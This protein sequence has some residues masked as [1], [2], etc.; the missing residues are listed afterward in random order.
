VASPTII[1]GR[2][3]DLHVP[4]DRVKRHRLL[5]FLTA[6]FAAKFVVLLQLY[7]HP[8]LQANAGL[9]TTVYTSLAAK[10]LA[11]NPS[12]APGLYFV[13]PLYIYFLAAILSVS[14]SLAFARLVQIALGTAAV[15]MMFV[16]AR[17]WF[18]E[19]AGWCAAVLAALTGLFTFH[20]VLILQAALD[21]FLT[22]AALTA[23]ALA[24]TA[25]RAQMWF[26]VSGIAFG[27]QT[28]NRPSVLIP[29]LVV[30]ALLSIARRWRP[31]IFMAAG[32]AIAL[33]P[34]VIRNGIVARD[35]SPASSHGGLN[36]YIGNNADANGT[37]HLVPG[38][39]PN[40][41]GQQEDARRVAEASVGRPLDDSEVAAYFYGLGWTWIR[42]HPKD[43][44]ALFARKL[45]YTFSSAYITLNYSYPFYAYDARTLL[46]LLFVGP[47][48]LIPVG[49]VGL[50]I[51]MPADRRF[52]Y[53]VWVSFVPVYAIAVATF[54]VTERYRLPMLVPLCMGSGVTVD[55]IFRLKAEA[56]KFK[57][58]KA[59]GTGFQPEIFALLAIIPLA[60]LVNWPVHL[61]DG[62]AEERTRMAEAMVAGDEYDDAEEWVQ[63]AERDH[64]SPGLLHFRVARA[65]IL[66]RQPQR[67]IDH[68][69][70]SIQ[71]DPNRPEVDYAYGQALVDAG[72]SAE[73]IPHLRN[74]MR[75][76]VRVDLAGYDLARALAATGNRAG[77]LQ[78]L[79]TV[80]PE[81]PK[82]AD[83]W[84]ALGQLA[85]QLESPSLAAAFFNQALAA[86]P[87]TAKPMADLGL[88]LAMMGRYPEAI[89]NFTHA[90]AL[91][92]AN[93]A[94]ELNLAVAYAETGR[95][96]EARAHAEAA[97]RLKPDYA[98]ARQFLAALPRGK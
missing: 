2:E 36:F 1:A 20:E 93:A 56:T 90:L 50:V 82:D 18:G 12:L 63:K 45:G 94:T 76:G 65:Y 39:T 62:R 86:A 69:K 30:L 52:E 67:A 23:L 97:L 15:W 7:D 43:A 95:I 59:N 55:A 87:Q 16:G 22:A 27:I 26:A 57:R 40:I 31:A 91:D 58:R 60:I 81:N 54:F 80:K 28:L 53:L 46:A 41:A 89:S 85:L 17:A 77:A 79:Q 10:V 70:R 64:P 37:Y 61:D 32:L 47:W 68:L 88:A 98:K 13:S 8:L 35:W 75:A 42:L 33:S 14:G 3:P 78:I 83:S 5:I 92:P 25:R 96:A 73:A 72:R 4:F 74:A 34:V 84:D 51:G 38:I 19:R 6:V 21:P 48:L 11:G 44:F 9:D 71:I 66:H 29:C 49:V 24:L